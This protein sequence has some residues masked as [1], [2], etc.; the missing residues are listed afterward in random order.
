MSLNSGFHEAESLRHSWSECYPCFLR[1][2]V[3]RVV[4]I[5]RCRRRELSYTPPF[6]LRQPE[7]LFYFLTFDSSEESN[8]HWN[9]AP[10]TEESSSVS[11]D[12]FTIC[13]HTATLNDQKLR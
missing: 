3:R 9:C 10:K 13:L 4:F 12:A 8:Q 6:Q 5:F 11:V 1:S 7:S 2:T